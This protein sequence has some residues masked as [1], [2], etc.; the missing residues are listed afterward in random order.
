MSKLT[1]QLRAHAF[2]NSHDFANARGVQNSNY[3][4]DRPAPRCRKYREHHIVPIIMYLP[5]ERGRGSRSARWSVSQGNIPTDPDTHWQNYG[6]KTFVVFR[7]G[8]KAAKFEEAVTWASDY[9]GVTEW[10][11]EP[12]GSWMPSEFVD[13]RL[14]QLK[15]WMKG[16]S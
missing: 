10:K 6:H 1:E 12:F 16:L 4:F 13:A 15:D 8:E 2:V 14:K 7:Q 11:R 5:A 9:F 3:P